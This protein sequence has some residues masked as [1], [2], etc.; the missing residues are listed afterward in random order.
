MMKEYSKLLE[1]FDEKN[2]YGFKSEIKG[3]LKGLGFDDED[4][5][6]KVSVLSGGQ[7]QGFP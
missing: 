6:K 2:G 3:V 1:E 5:D 4:M 7:R